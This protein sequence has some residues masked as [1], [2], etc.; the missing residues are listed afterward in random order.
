ML[1]KQVFLKIK[2]KRKR[3][4]KSLKQQTNTKISKHPEKTI[5]N[6]I[7]VSIVTKI[8]VLLT[9]DFRTLQNIYY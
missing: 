9:R 4:L 8:N 5:T 1:Q 7:Q 6:F 2:N 3:I